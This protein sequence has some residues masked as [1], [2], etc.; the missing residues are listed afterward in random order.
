LGAA[1][2]SA[3][4]NSFHFTIS[5]RKSRALSGAKGS[6][7][8]AHLFGTSREIEMGRRSAAPLKQITDRGID[9]LQRAADFLR[10]LK[11]F[12]GQDFAAFEKGS[13]R[14]KISQAAYIE[15]A[16]EDR[17]RKGGSLAARGSLVKL[18]LQ[19]RET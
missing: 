11:H 19:D 9:E 7:S 13:Q 3:P 14:R 16:S 12:A 5:Y 8:Y 17:F 4:R 6:Q 15:A 2:D 1:S 18:I 10:P